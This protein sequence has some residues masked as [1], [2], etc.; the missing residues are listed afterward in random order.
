MSQPRPQPE[1]VTVVIINWNGRQHLEVCLAALERLDPA[2]ARLLLVDNASTDDSLAFTRERYPG[3]D[4]LALPSNGGPCPARNAGLRA[5][6]TPWVLLVDNDAIPEPDALAR[7]LEAIEPGVACVQPRALLAAEPGR[8]HYD[9]AR[10]HFAGIMLLENY[11][12]PLADAGDEPRDLGAT[13]SFALLLDRDAALNAGGFDPAHFILFEDHDFSYRLRAMGQRIVHA[14]RARFL[15]R[16]GTEGISFREKGSYAGRR[17]YLHSR[18]RWIVLLKCHRLRTLL[19]TS[20]ALALYESLYF[21]F[22]L[23]EMR[24]ADWFAGKRDLLKLLP[25]ILRDRRRVAANRKRPDRELLVSGPLTVSPLIERGSATV[26][27]QSAVEFLMS[28]WWRLIQRW[29]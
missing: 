22:A 19:L 25:Q 27:I 11:Y 26:K 17:V 13:I 12:R 20:P 18:N 10:I 21:A 2:P 6:R 5:A 15:H 4:I 23:R 14:P 16:D 8:I 1:D 9:G 24:L 28:V 7:M 29:V 3:V